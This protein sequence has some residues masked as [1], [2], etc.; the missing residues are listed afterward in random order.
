MGFNE[1]ARSDRVFSNQANYGAIVVIITELIWL[2]K[3]PI[4]LQE[5]NHVF[6]KTHPTDRILL[7]RHRH[8]EGN[9]DILRPW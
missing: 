7:N 6:C 1:V 5:L 3:H 9:V 4:G 2:Q 8:V